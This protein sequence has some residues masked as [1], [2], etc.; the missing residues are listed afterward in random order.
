MVQRP[1]AAFPC[2][3]S[4]LPPMTW[5]PGASSYVCLLPSQQSFAELDIE[6]WGHA[7]SCL[8]PDHSKQQGQDLNPVLLCQNLI[9]FSLESW[10]YQREGVPG[11]EPSVP[12]LGF[13]CEVGIRAFWPTPLRVRGQE[14]EPAHPEDLFL[15][16]FLGLCP[17]LTSSSL[18]SAPWFSGNSP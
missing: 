1:P 18:L 16:S 10:Y 17:L 13:S 7:I 15:F 3:E 9:L 12:M 11:T 8:R 5:A 14:V 6:A 4:F 2:R